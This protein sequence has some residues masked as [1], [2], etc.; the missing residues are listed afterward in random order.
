L[1]GAV[2]LGRSRSLTTEKAGSAPILKNSFLT[3]IGRTVKLEIGPA[4]FTVFE[5]R[6]GLIQKTYGA[7][8]IAALRALATPEM[9]SY[10]AVEI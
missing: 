5:Q 4:D 8:D 6:L 10:F 3:P 2:R 1:T 9:A 7:E